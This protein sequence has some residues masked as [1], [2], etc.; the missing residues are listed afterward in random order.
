[1]SA[2]LLKN[3]R[4]LCLMLILFFFAGINS[5]IIL[6][7]IRID[8]ELKFEENTPLI[9]NQITCLCFVAAVTTFMASSRVPGV[10]YASSLMAMGEFDHRGGD[11]KLDQFDDVKM[12]IPPNALVGM[13]L[14]YFALELDHRSDFTTTMSPIFICGPPG[15]NFKEGVSFP[16]NMA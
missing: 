10:C 13:Q 9:Q 11:L 1:M 16:H 15:L 14:V 8:C 7:E 12:I 2:I 4:D 6:V 3:D 5:P